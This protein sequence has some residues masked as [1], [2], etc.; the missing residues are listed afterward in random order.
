MH[1]AAQEGHLEMIQ[2][3][4]DCGANLRVVCTKK[5]T[6]LM[7]AARYAHVEVLRY[8]I[9]NGADV[10]AIDSRKTSAL[11]FACDCEKLVLLSDE[12]QREDIEIRYLDV[13]YE[14]LAH[15]ANVNAKDGNG[16]T[17]VVLASAVGH[18][19]LVECLVEHGAR[20]VPKLGNMTEFIESIKAAAGEA[21]KR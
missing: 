12:S 9:D 10:K 14:L 16:L 8:L 7:C 4:K 20:K 15:G 18:T 19:D 17:P 1:V 3:L 6:L 21:K 11:H 2:L 5:S 13:A